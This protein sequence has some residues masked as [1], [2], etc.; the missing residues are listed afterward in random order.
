MRE[1][2]PI[3]H[4]LLDYTSVSGRCNHN[5]HFG[6]LDRWLQLNSSC[7]YCRDEINHLI[8][9]ENNETYLYERQFDESLDI[10]DWD[11]ESIDFQH[12]YTIIPVTN[13]INIYILSIPIVICIKIIEYK[14]IIELSIIVTLVIVNLLKYIYR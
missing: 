7:P 4:E 14:N 5:F 12:N 1:F 3:C 11:E 9:P 6:C 10:I 2:C 13:H 8:N